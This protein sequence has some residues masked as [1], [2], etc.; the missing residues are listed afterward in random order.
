VAAPLL[1]FTWNWGGYA[2]FQ[3]YT[4]LYAAPRRN[5]NVSRSPAEVKLCFADNVFLNVNTA[6]PDQP[7]GT[8][9]IRNH[10]PLSKALKTCAALRRQFLPYFCDGTLIGDCLL[11]RRV[12]GTHVTAYV[13]G[14]RALMV[15]LNRGASQTIELLPNLADWLGGPYGFEARAFGE[16]GKCRRQQVLDRPDA[17]ISTG[18]MATDELCLVEIS[19]CPR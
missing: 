14:D 7:N 11:N 9:R 5:A 12:P 4:S 19:R 10:P 13:R 3:P 2:D 1:D 18:V 17:P 8:D 6:A 15:V 16:D